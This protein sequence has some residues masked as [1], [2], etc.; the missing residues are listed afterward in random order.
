MPE[1]TINASR[2]WVYPAAILATAGLTF[3]LTALLMNIN[4]R[5]QEATQTFVRVVE[6]DENTVDPAV[7]G[8]NFPRQYDGYLRTA[9]NERSQYGGSEALPPEKL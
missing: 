4:Q 2:R 3:G 9:D 6:L 8:K 7:W 1:P 5:K